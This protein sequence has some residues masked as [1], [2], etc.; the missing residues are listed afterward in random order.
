MALFFKLRKNKQ[1][2]Y[3]PRYYDEKKERL[4]KFKTQYGDNSRKTLEK[5]MRGKIK[6]HQPQAVPGFFSKANLRTLIILGFLVLAVY[7]FLKKFNF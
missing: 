3:T 1:Y 7:Y 4:E 6:R 2:S 5:R